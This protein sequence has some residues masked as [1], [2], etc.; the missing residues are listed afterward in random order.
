MCI[1]DRFYDQI[2]RR[3]EVPITNE[4]KEKVKKMAKEMHQYYERRYT[5]KV[6]TGPFCKNCSLQ[7]ICLP[8]LMK[9]RTVRSYIEG[10]LGE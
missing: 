6:K 7:H 4:L 3:V 5:P 2:K 10:R 9:K 8:Q 1:R